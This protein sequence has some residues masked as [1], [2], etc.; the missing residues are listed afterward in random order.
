[1]AGVPKDHGLSDPMDAIDLPTLKKRLSPGLLNIGGVS[2]VGIRGG[3]L[4][5]YLEVDSKAVR[6]AVEK[7]VGAEAAEVPVTYVVTGK[8]HA[9]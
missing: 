9:H 6:E 3:T 2:G 4:T 5:V 1:M 8:F 7:F